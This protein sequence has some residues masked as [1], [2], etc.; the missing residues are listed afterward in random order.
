MLTIA[1]DIA[2]GQ[3]TT[4]LLLV[5]LLEATKSPFSSN[6]ASADSHHPH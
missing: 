1:S 2:I 4:P 6:P 5:V 3:G